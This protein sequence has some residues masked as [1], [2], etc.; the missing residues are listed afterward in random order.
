MNV[1]YHLSRHGVAALPV[2][3]VGRDILGAELIRRLKGWGIDTRHVA[4]I[5]RKPT[6]TV[7]VE[8]DKAGKP[9]YEI[10]EGV[11]WDQIRVSAPLL[12]QARRSKAVVFGS[13]AQRTANNRRQLAKILDAASHAWRVFDINLRPPFDDLELVRNLARRSSLLKLNDEE[14]SR[15][16]NRKLATPQ[17]ESSA[18]K[19]AEETNCGRICVTAGAQGAGLLWEGQWYWEKSR[20]IKVKDSVGAGDSFLASLLHGLLFAQIPIRQALAKA[21]R[22]AEFVAASDGATPYYQAD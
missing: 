17:L 12:A 9:H 15:F 2:T 11:A 7:Q 16:A 14:L 18:R 21:C 5:P 20:K 1:A 13:L 4:T 6:G 10:V 3:A 19:L 22:L 8:L